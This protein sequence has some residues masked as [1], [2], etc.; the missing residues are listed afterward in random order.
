MKKTI[1]ESVFIVIFILSSFTLKAQE[2]I[3]LSLEKAIEYALQYN[4]VLQNAKF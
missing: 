4:K 2:S 3:S 1:K